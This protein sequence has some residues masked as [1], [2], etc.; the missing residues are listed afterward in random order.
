[1]GLSRHNNLLH[2]FEIL[3]VCVEHK[4]ILEV[5]AGFYGWKAVVVVE[6][7]IAHA[8]FQAYF[9]EDEA[10][11]E[12]WLFFGVDQGEGNVLN[13][14]GVGVKKLIFIENLVVVYVFVK[15]HEFWLHWDSATT[16]FQNLSVGIVYVLGYKYDGGFN[17]GV[18]GDGLVFVLFIAFVDKSWLFSL[19]L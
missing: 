14:E 18:D 1:M 19:F 8:D 17:W 3:K 11:L 5:Y 12:E 4:F 9:F 16:Q 15:W 2:Y 13:L 7:A 6:Q 10:L